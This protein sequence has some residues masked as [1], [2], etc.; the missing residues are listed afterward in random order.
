MHVH[1]RIDASDDGKI[2]S[3]FLMYYTY[4]GRQHALC[5]QPRTDSFQ[6]ILVLL[7]LH[8]IQF[9]G[10]YFDLFKLNSVV[11][12]NSNLSPSWFYRRLRRN[13]LISNRRLHNQ[14]R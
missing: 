2:K 12:M 3:N 11:V 14:M 4:D 1:T 8:L 5:A 9:A 13:F 6:C 10:S 7:P